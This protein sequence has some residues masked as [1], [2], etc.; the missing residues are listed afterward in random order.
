MYDKELTET[1]KKVDKILARRTI[2]YQLGYA[3]GENKAYTRV[4]DIL[5]HLDKQMC[6]LVT[7]CEARI[8]ADVIEEILSKQIVIV[9]DEGLVYSV[10]KVKDIKEQK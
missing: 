7:D 3:E 8:R 1:R 10:V 5:E 6:E 2:E 9:D 4:L